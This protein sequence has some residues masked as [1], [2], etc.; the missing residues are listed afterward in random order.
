VTFFVLIG[1]HI[2]LTN[3]RSKG[4]VLVPGL[5]SITLAQG[6]SGKSRHLSPSSS[7]ELSVRLGGEGVLTEAARYLKAKVAY[8]VQGKE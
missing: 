5:L 8:S 7:R 4:E 1:R 3:Q 6:V 2:K